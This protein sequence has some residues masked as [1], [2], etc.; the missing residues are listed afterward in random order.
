MLLKVIF[1]CAILIISI[2]NV[3]KNNID[4][5]SGIHTGSQ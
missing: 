5:F 1:S 3:K 2:E 4:Y